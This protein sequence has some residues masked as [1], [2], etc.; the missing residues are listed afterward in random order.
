MDRE[1][2][3]SPNSLRAPPLSGCDR[4]KERAG[5]QAGRWSS[6]DLDM[7]INRP[8]SNAGVRDL[9]ERRRSVGEDLGR[10]RWRSRTELRRK[11]PRRGAATDINSNLSRRGSRKECRRFE[12]RRDAK[13]SLGLAM[14]RRRSGTQ[15]REA[16]DPRG[17]VSDLGRRKMKRGA[18]K[19]RRVSERELKDLTSNMPETEAEC[20]KGPRLR[21]PP[22]RY[23]Q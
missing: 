4:G 3:P 12:T 19:L 9:P 16:E 8:R 18:R 6:S 23:G 21:K 15:L 17:A 14:R 10:R 20:W 11:E 7:Q 13:L 22:E 1:F 5:L 2:W